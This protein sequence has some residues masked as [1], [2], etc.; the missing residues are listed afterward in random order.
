MDVGVFIPIGHDGRPI[1]EAAPHY[2][3]SFALDRAI[4]QK[5]DGSGLEFA[6]SMIALHG[7]DTLFNT[8]IQPL[9]ACRQDRVEVAA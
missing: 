8:R 2:E 3:P 9:M 6:L 7:L 4:V 1:S 5:A